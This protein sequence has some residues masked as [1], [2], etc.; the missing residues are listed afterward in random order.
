MED[1]VVKEVPRA[2]HIH[3]CDRMNQRLLHC[4]DCGYVL[5]YGRATD[6]LDFW[7]DISGLMQSGKDGLMV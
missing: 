3:R 4:I 6:K 1:E 5:R 7:Q 2:D